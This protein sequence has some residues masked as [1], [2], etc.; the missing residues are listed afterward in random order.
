MD[1]EQLNIKI[2][3]LLFQ[4]L[5]EKSCMCMYTKSFSYNV[6]ATHWEIYDVNL[7]TKNYRYVSK[8]PFVKNAPPLTP[9]QIAEEEAE[10]AKEQKIQEAL[11]YKEFIN[12]F[13]VMD[14]LSSRKVW[15]EKGFAFDEATNKKYAGEVFNFIYDGLDIQDKK[16]FITIAPRFFSHETTQEIVK[17]NQNLFDVYFTSAI[18]IFV[19]TF[20]YSDVPKL[21]NIFHHFHYK[22]NKHTY[23]DMLY[24]FCENHRTLL[25]HVEA[26]SLIK[27]HVDKYIENTENFS[28]FFE[29]ISNSDYIVHEGNVK[30][31]KIDKNA[32]YTAINLNVSLNKERVTNYLMYLISYLARSENSRLKIINAQVLKTEPKIKHHTIVFDCFENNPTIDFTDLIQK[33]VFWTMH[34][35][36]KTNN[37]DGVFKAAINRYFIER[38]MPVKTGNEPSIKRNKI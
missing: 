8:I 4:W 1:K 6:N 24:K 33:I 2:K 38:D 3:N 7:V 34:A 10:K 20:E 16:D 19:G 9:K 15:K 13:K 22:G 26:Q 32:F 27:A 36:E 37:L 5:E 11:K 17:S 21:L 29:K 28:V 23:E 18:P 31:I 30:Y 25:K 12:A 14:V 35:V